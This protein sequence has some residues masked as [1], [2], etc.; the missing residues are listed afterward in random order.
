MPY[1]RSLCSARRKSYS[2]GV[3]TLASLPSRF[4][5]S[6][7]SCALPPCCS[8]LP[9]ITSSMTLAVTTRGSSTS[10]TR[11]SS[12][13]PG[14]MYPCQFRA[15]ICAFSCCQPR[16]WVLSQTYAGGHRRQPGK[17]RGD[18]RPDRPT[19]HGRTILAVHDIQPGTYAAPSVGASPGGSS[20]FEP[21]RSA[22]YFRSHARA[23]V[24]SSFVD[25]SDMR[26]S[27][28]NFAAVSW[29]ASG[30]AMS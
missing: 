23:W 4:T 25:R 10:R 15:R 21:L 17:H 13:P 12:S 30:R 19:I 24:A 1:P 16:H 9:S 26:K 5:V 2:S 7:R 20:G 14:L 6:R 11:Q 22:T 29:S 28:R 18:A 3:G 27:A 8:P